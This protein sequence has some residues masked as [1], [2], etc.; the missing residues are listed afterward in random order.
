[1]QI[2]SYFV[3]SVFL[4]TVSASRIKVRKRASVVDKANIAI[5]RV[6][7]YLNEH[8]P[9][10]TEEVTGLF[11][12]F[13]IAYLT[14][15]GLSD[16]TADFAVDNTGFIRGMFSFD[17]INMHGSNLTA[18]MDDHP[19]LHM[20]SMNIE[21]EGLTLKVTGYFDGY[22]KKFTQLSVSPQIE[23]LAG[24]FTVDIRSILTLQ[25]FNDVSEK[26]QREYGKFLMDALNI[27]SL[28]EYM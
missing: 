21:L 2:I 12:M 24:N 26:D 17:L 3:M 15:Y 8:D 13:D 9:L 1:M 20:S 11:N 4:T 23:N 6:E 5:H 14:T 18:K 28:A 25:D 7:S 22:S 16:F 27:I 10:V 19:Y